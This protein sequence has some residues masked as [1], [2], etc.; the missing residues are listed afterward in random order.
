META[1]GCHD[2]GFILRLLYG[3]K[4]AEHIEAWL[5]ERL[6]HFNPPPAR[7]INQGDVLLTV[8]PHQFSR[9]GEQGLAALQRILD[10]L[11]DG[12]F[13]GLHLLPFYDGTSSNPLAVTDLLAVDPALGG[14]DDIRRLGE[15]L[16]LAL[17]VPLNGLSTE[18]RVYK[19]F[20]ARQPPYDQFFLTKTPGEEGDTALPPRFITCETAA[21]PLGVYSTFGEG[22]ADLDYAQAP[23]FEYA[24][25]ALLTC[26]ENG[27]QIIRLTDVAHLVKGGGGLH[28]PQTHLLVRA[29]R[30]LLDGIAPHVQLVA[31]SGLL[32]SEPNWYIGNGFNEVHLAQHT[33]LMDDLAQARLSGDARRLTRHA[34]G[35]A[36]PCNRVSLYHPLPV[37][38]GA[39]D[40]GLRVTLAAGLALAGVPSVRL[41]DLLAA[42][43]DGFKLDA[44]RLAAVAD[45]LRARH[46]QAAFDPHGAQL[47][48]DVGATVFAVLR[49]SPDLMEQALCLHNFSPAPCKVDG[50]LLAD[51]SGMAH[52]NDLLTGES[53]DLH[54]EVVLPGYAVWWLR[55]GHKGKGGIYHPVKG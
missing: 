21:G 31:E 24:L 34:G 37:F 55:A 8:D 25:D 1:C 14:W 16:T 49:I 13:S 3:G 26:I 51:A 7:P 50:A 35:I 2:P 12:L 17:D 18:S 15:R 29:L 22:L 11:P 40:A 33:P 23:V 19:A 20:I 27:A 44:R 39:T 10:D 54:G 48:L 36:L 5:A 42:E 38:A 45:L 47:V 52:A 32:F 53:V 28:L 4:D 9:G 30:A 43:G 6:T 46:A 41:S